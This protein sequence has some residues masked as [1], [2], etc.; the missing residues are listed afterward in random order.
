MNTP[1][2]GA[3]SASVEIC[4]LLRKPEALQMPVQARYVTADSVGYLSVEGMAKATGQPLNALC[5]A[6]F[7]GDY[8]VEI[9]VSLSK[10]VL[11]TPNA[12]TEMPSGI[13]TASATQVVRLCEEVARLSPSELQLAGV[14][15]DRSTTLATGAAVI[16]G[17]ISLRRAATRSIVCTRLC[18]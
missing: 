18:R 8:P 16:S 11:E 13:A 10:A 17:I 6:C 2:V 9:P 3:G 5:L 1:T 7:T 4:T 14:D 12:R 15:A